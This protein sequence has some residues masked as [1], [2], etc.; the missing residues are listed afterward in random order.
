MF[1]SVFFHGSVLH[2]AFNM[3]A[4]VPMV[5]PPVHVDSP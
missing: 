2:L 3:M 5:P 4:F 1:T